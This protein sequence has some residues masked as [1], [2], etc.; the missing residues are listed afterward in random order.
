MTLPSKFA[1]E[2]ELPVGVMP[3]GPQLDKRKFSGGGAIPPWQRPAFVAAGSG[4]RLYARRGED[5]FLPSTGQGHIHDVSF[6]HMDNWLAVLKLDELIKSDDI[7]IDLLTAYKVA[8]EFESISLQQAVSDVRDSLGES[9]ESPHLAEIFALGST[10]EVLSAALRMDF[11]G[12][13]SGRES[14]GGLGGFRP[15]C[16]RAGHDE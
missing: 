10:G 11:P 12:F 5:Q 15:T 13:L 8:R 4:D 3:L 2:F 9:A 14:G 16:V 7:S 1:R 6:F